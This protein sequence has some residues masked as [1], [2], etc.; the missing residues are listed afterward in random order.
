MKKKKQTKKTTTKRCMKIKFGQLGNTVNGMYGRGKQQGCI[1]VGVSLIPT[2][3]SHL[4]K[5]EKRRHWCHSVAI[6]AAMP[7]VCQ[8]HIH[9]N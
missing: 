9:S 5:K 3:K 2:F 8:Y 4:K 7:E 6:A 1:G